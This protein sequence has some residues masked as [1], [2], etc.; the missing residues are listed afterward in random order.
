MHEV[1]Y[2]AVDAEKYSE[3][4]KIAVEYIDEAISKSSGTEKTR[5]QA[6]R[7]Q[8]AFDAGSKDP[9]VKERTIAN[10]HYIYAALSRVTMTEKKHLTIDGAGTELDDLIKNLPAGKYKAETLA[11]LKEV[12]HRV[13][14]EDGAF[15]SMMSD[16]Q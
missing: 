2:A 15:D 12:G 8:M 7:P 9:A 4:A 14:K 13:L 3:A 10:I 16:E 1:Y 11:K 5:L 6:L